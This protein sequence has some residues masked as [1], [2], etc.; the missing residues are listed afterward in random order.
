MTTS[1]AP[2]GSWPSPIDASSLTAGVVKLLDVW[3]DIVDGRRLTVWHEGRP[4]DGG[5]QPL[6]TQDAD[7]RHRDL[8][9]PPFSARSAAHEYGGGAAWVEGG[10]AWFV[11]WDDQRVWRVP[12][13][14]ST[15]PVA[16][17]PEPDRPRHVRYADLRRSPD[18]A[19]LLAVRERHAPDDPPDVTNEVVLLRAHEPSEPQVVFAGTD[20][21]MSP[22]FTAPDEIRFVAWDHPDM[23]WTDTALMR[24]A[25][26][27][28]AGTSGAVTTLAAGG[29]F[30]QPVADTVL[31]D[32]SGWWNRWRISSTE[33]IP[34]WP[35]D[36]EIGGPAWIFGL[37]SLFAHKRRRAFVPGQQ[38][39]RHPAR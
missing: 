22:R 23:P 9:A 3:V 5:R 1:V 20:F 12:V 15:D 30:M 35:S 25:F 27:P 4:A 13:D 6:V 34:L 21:V 33:A 17:T 32:R 28:I 8:F 14:G 38:L 2:Y 10:V 16:L 26:D 29:S 31:H 11:N 39:Q 7:G 19:W 24:C 18:G 36:A 37:R